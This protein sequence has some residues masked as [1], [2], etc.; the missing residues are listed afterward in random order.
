VKFN[1]EIKDDFLVTW[2]ARVGARFGMVGKVVTF[3][4]CPS[5]GTFAT[6]CQVW[7]DLLIN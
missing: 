4:V 1:D 6:M 2:K 3:K 5:F 7:N